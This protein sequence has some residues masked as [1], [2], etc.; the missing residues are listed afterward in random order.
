MRARKQNEIR[1]QK[2]KRA[3][4]IDEQNEIEDKHERALK[5]YETWKLEKDK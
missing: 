2:K 4:L 1:K 5:R 3:K